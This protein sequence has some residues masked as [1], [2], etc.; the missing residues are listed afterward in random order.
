VKI[1]AQQAFQQAGGSG[2]IR[3]TKSGKAKKLLYVVFPSP[4]TLAVK[5]II[6]KEGYSNAQA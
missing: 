3:L 5:L 4:R 6:F 1:T 2:Q